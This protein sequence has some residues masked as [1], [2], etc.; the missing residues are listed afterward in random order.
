MEQELIDLKNAP[1]VQPWRLKLATWVES[2]PIQLLVVATIM[3]NAV[4]LGLETSAALMDV[5][6]PILLTLDRVCLGIFVIELL[7][8][9]AAYQ[10]RFWKSP[11]NIFDL[12]VVVI[13]LVPG[14]GPW[15]VL[16]TL[17][18]LRVLRLLTVV[19]SL[20]IVVAAFLHSIPGLTGVA[21]VMLIFFYV[22]SVLV[23][24]LFGPSFPEWFGS[25][26]R[27]L[28]TLFQIMTLESWSMGVVRPIMETYPYAWLFFVP[29]II[30][31]TFTIL[32][33]FIGIIVSTMQ[34]LSLP[35]PRK[36]SDEELEKVLNQLED[37]LEEL[38]A[39]LK[40]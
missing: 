1:D 28:Y 34:E 21:A 38:K 37:G 10:W 3:I 30:I 12:I 20:R 19:P 4:V 8:K 23:T 35:Q 6:G 39:R 15:A 9:L 17:R 22:A 13:A 14:A 18:V 27:S 26:G 2:R 25:I 29:F 7:L 16:R 32:N 5:Y 36:A 11:W 33:L 31:A 24:K 40:K